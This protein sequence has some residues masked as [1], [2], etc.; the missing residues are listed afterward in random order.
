MHSFG[1]MHRRGEEA[2]ARERGL[3][4]FQTCVRL[5][6]RHVERVEN[7]ADM[8]V[9]V[10]C[11]RKGNVFA[12]APH[13]GAVN[14]Q[15]TRIDETIELSLVMARE[16]Q[17]GDEGLR[18]NG[19]VHGAPPLPG[20]ETVMSRLA[21]REG[22]MHG[23]VRDCLAVN[24]AR[25]MSGAQATSDELF[26]MQLGG[27]L[28]VRVEFV[29]VQDTEPD[30]KSS[31]EQ[32]NHKT[33]ALTGAL[34][35]SLRQQEAPGENEDGSEDDDG[36]AVSERDDRDGRNGIGKRD[37]STKKMDG[38]DERDETHGGGDTD[39][40]DETGEKYGTA[41][42]DGIAR[43][44]EDE[45]VD[46]EEEDEEEEDEADAGEDDVDEGHLIRRASYRQSLPAAMEGT[47][48][49]PASDE[50][51]SDEYV[52]VVE[53]PQHPLT[54][55]VLAR[56]RCK[57][58]VGEYSEGV[59]E[60]TPTLTHFKTPMEICVWSIQGPDEEE[61]DD[62]EEMI[63]VGDGVMAPKRNI[64][65]LQSLYNCSSTKP[66]PNAQRGKMSLIQKTHLWSAQAYGPTVI[67][68]GPPVTLSHNSALATSRMIAQDVQYIDEP[69]L[70]DSEDSPSDSGS[71]ASDSTSD[72][73][74]SSVRLR[75]V[76]PRV[77]KDK[78]LPNSPVAIKSS[79][80]YGSVDATSTT[81]E[82]L[83]QPTRSSSSEGSSGDTATSSVLREQ[84]RCSADVPETA[85]EMAGLV[86]RVNELERE[87]QALQRIA[88]ESREEAAENGR[89][90]AGM[91]E[92][93][94]RLEKERASNSEGHAEAMAAIRRLRMELDEAREQRT[95]KGTD[96]GELE[97]MRIENARLLDVILSL[98][99][100]LDREPG[101]PDVM[102][103][104]LAA[105]TALAVEQAR[106]EQLE[107]TVAMLQSGASPKSSSADRKKAGGFFGLS[108]NS[109]KKQKAHSAP[110]S[111]RFSDASDSN[112]PR[113]VVDP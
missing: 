60:E 61:D 66:G 76:G 67:D 63:D 100:E 47:S 33:L 48:E 22:S 113:S 17:Y 6:V 9:V 31:V 16:S 75:R 3:N 83:Y 23:S 59:W 92:H 69:D 97:T 77:C 96:S 10:T 68:L 49:E 18:E 112:S 25:F 12:T 98:K 4:T 53:Q 106:R 32:P 89:K 101:S 42:R 80:T 11:E 38:T 93:A 19:P 7:I 45:D 5:H 39:Q 94:L 85:A 64:R 36:V 103:E 72:T 1:R 41:E 29:L 34:N 111:P 44:D 84:P 56:H 14:G 28:L 2:D 13:A 30:Q 40:G 86:Q 91:Q 105:K 73:S 90:L 46:D 99:R 20:F 65:Q 79:L 81:G 109:T 58:F 51:A 78:S 74:G 26:E 95:G 37:C 107:H 108:K 21:I 8:P 24:L 70:S 62:E 15:L 71:D 52:H 54:P 82:E 55:L 88:H 43:R 102:Q 57:P 87:N 50:N 35:M 104:L 27:G 110:S